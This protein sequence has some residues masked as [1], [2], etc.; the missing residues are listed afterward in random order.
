M[1][2]AVRIPGL[3]TGRLCGRIDLP[4]KNTCV[5]CSRQE[6]DSEGADS[7]NVQT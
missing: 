6:H 2:R 4:F 1:G 7:Q 5:H 3:Q